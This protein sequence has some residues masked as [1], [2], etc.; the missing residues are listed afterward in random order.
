MKFDRRFTEL[1]RVLAA[2]EPIILRMQDGSV[3]PL[4]RRRGEDLLALLNR[5]LNEAESGNLSSDVALIQQSIAGRESG[6][7]MI[8]LDP[9]DFA[10]RAGGSGNRNRKGECLMDAANL[11]FDAKYIQNADGSVTPRPWLQRSIQATI[12]GMKSR[13]SA[14]D[15]AERQPMN[16][17]DAIYAGMRGKPIDRNS[18]STRG[19]R[20]LRGARATRNTKTISRNGPEANAKK[21]PAIENAAGPAIVRQGAISLKFDAAPNKHAACRFMRGVAD[22]IRIQESRH[23]RAQPARR[24]N[25]FSDAG[26][27]RTHGAVNL[28]GPVTSSRSITSSFGERPAPPIS[29]RD[30]FEVINASLVPTAAIGSLNGDLLSACADLRRRIEKRLSE[31]SGDRRAELSAA[32]QASLRPGARMRD[33]INRLVGSSAARMQ[34]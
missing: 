33:E 10:N 14:A 8:E 29:L 6:G 5:S 13:I 12:D 17:L 18:T 30:A 25:R 23:G 7:R 1:E 2:G 34:N 11:S 22:G 21:M 4:R 31:Q 3:E 15:A 9:L 27:A 16:P 24:R 28:S 32:H 19:G 26:D 20:R